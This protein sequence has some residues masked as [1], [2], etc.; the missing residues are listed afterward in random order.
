MESF[1]IL[2]VTE[3]P[4]DDTLLAGGRNL[5]ARPQAILAPEGRSDRLSWGADSD[6]N[7]ESA[8]RHD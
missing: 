1:G 7:G 8:G 5:Y 3:G 6:A 2:G 4:I